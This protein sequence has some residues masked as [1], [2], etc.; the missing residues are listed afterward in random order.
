MC[1][2][3]VDIGYN[4][5]G[6]IHSFSVRYEK[7]IFMSISR[8]FPSIFTVTQFLILSAKTVRSQTELDKKLKYLQLMSRVTEAEVTAA[9]E[10]GDNDDDVQKEGFVI[11]VAELEEAA[12][13]EA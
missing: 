3:L 4:Y 7:P 1:L 10:D 5:T 13:G 12:A 11:V 6:T 8:S 9:D 2:C